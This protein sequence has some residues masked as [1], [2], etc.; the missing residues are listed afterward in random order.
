MRTPVGKSPPTG[1]AAPAC[2]ATAK[3]AQ[4]M[5]ANVRD[6]SGKGELP[7]IQTGD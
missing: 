1:A 2:G 6:D 5:R 7:I 3:A 4:N